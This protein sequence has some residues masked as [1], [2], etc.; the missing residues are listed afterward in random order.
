MRKS[1][2]SS[3]VISFTTRQL[4]SMIRLSEAHSKMRLS[5]IVEVCDVEEANRLILSALQTAAVDPRTGKIDLDLVTTGISALSRQIHYDL[6]KALRRQIESSANGTS[7]N[8]IKWP[9]LLRKFQADSDAV[10]F[11]FIFRLSVK[12]LLMVF[13]LIWSM[14]DIFM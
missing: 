12:V 2:Q 13:L 6:R 3:G 1:S 8:S 11:S 10:F 4:E 5:S 14:K 7:G 9:E